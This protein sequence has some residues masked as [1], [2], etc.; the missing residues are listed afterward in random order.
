MHKDHRG[1]R[2]EEIQFDHRSELEV[3]VDEGEEEE[4]EE[5]E[6]EGGEEEGGES[7][8]MKTIKRTLVSSTQ[9]KKL[10]FTHR[11]GVLSIPVVK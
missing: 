7:E 11:V 4:G 2:E 6:E 9:M 10:Q 8:R 1:D 3:E 5:G